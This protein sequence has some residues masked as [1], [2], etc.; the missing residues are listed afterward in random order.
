[1]LLEPEVKIL[2]VD[3]R[4]E[5]VLALEAVLA[6]P[7]YH[8]IS[9]RSGQE[10][11]ARLA[12]HEFAVILMDVQM[13]KIDGFQ[14]AALIK[15]RPEWKDIPILFVTAIPQE[16]PYIHEGYK[17]GAVDYLFKPIDPYILRSKVA[18][19]AELY[20][21]NVRIRHAQ[22]EL[23]CKEE[24]LHQARKLEAIGRLAGGVAHDFN[25]IVTGI[26]GISHEV[27]DTLDPKDARWADMEEVIKAAHR[28]F[29]LTRHLL[30]YAR[31]QIISPQVL[32]LN[33][34]VS[35]MQ[36]LLVRLIGEDIQLRT[37]L[38]PALEP[39][40]ADRGY[41]EQVLINLVLNG[42]DAM[43][44]GG[45]IRIKTANVE[46][47]EDAL[48]Q[49]PLQLQ[50]GGY[51]LLSVADGGC[52]MNEE[53]LAH[54]F[55]PFFT[56]K[57]KEKG[58]G[59]GLATVYGIVKQTNGD[60]AVQSR[61]GS[62][63]VVEIYL[64]RMEKAVPLQTPES[65][66]VA[67]RGSETVLIVEDEDLVR[68]VVRTILRKQGYTVVEA[69]NGPEALALCE[70]LQNGIDLLITDVIMPE[71]NGRELAQAIIATHPEMAV[72]YMSG[73]SEDIIAKRGILDPGIAYIEK[74]AISSHLAV[75]VRQALS[76]PRADRHVHAS[77]TSAPASN[78]AKEESAA[79][80]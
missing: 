6:S 71:M 55:E 66:A 41:L 9:A 14:T 33:A 44:N 54:M 39:V 51:V 57:E 64:P 75:K 4:P 73:Y 24:E 17:V 43:P 62:G 52:G 63:T 79:I 37:E 45:T 46:L 47:T 15:Q 69:R 21:K 3:D 74:S 38:E 13:P 72:L 77:S 32:D 22:E 65:S 27:Q 18:V 53:V 58:T 11:I 60:V 70:R 49:R 40:N 68:R 36:E 1:M 19:F 2:I 29:S 20:R 26:L 59:L 12:E 23:R 78:L 35:D 80:K 61:P 67:P 56:T 34:I 31:R 7:G 42:R 48:R 28:A 16:T 8:L 25:N 76:S 50:A 5:G 30:A 10:A